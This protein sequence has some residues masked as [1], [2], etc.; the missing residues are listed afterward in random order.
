FYIMRQE[1]PKALNRSF[2][3]VD[4]DY[5]ASN[6]I[7]YLVSKGLLAGYPDGTFNPTGNITVREFMTV[8][9]RQIALNP[10]NVKPVVTNAIVPISPYSWGYIESKSILDRIPSIDLVRFN[11]YNM[12]RPITREEV[13]FLIDKALDLGLAYN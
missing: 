12:D 11:Y 4:E 10:K 9:S 7:N 6:N 1:K 13:A 8:L 3:D 2:N 5:W